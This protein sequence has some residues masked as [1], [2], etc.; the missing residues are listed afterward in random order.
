M[1][2]RRDE[3][4]RERPD[5]ESARSIM[6]WIDLRSA[7][8]KAPP[9]TTKATTRPITAGLVQPHSCRRSGRAGERRERRPR[10]GSSDIERLALTGRL[11]WEHAC[12]PEDR[13]QSDR[14]VDQEDRAP[15]RNLSQDTSERRSQAQ[16]YRDADS[17]NPR[18]RH[19]HRPGRSGYDRRSHGHDHGCAHTLDD[20]E[21]GQGR[22]VG[23]PRNRC[24]RA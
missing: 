22:D 14:R 18:A 13:Q 20:A 4:R 12:R 3:A 2:P 5:S 19:V 6:G 10:G 17:F 21:S 8:R 15:G 16:P 1:P 23:E 11:A 24:S 9:R 7:A